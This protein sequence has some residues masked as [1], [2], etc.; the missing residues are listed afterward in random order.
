[1]AISKSNVP[2]RVRVSVTK[3]PFDGGKSSY[4]ENVAMYRS[5]VRLD[6]KIRYG[7]AK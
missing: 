3:L 6:L 4:M 7:C 2:K 1:M 5:L